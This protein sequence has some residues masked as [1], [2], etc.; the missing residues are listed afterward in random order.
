ML[1]ISSYVFL[2]RRILVGYYMSAPVRSS[3]DAWYREWLS[4]VEVITVVIKFPGFYCYLPYLTYSN[5]KSTPQS[6]KPTSPF[7]LLEFS[8]ICIPW[9]YS[10]ISVKM[11]QHK[12]WGTLNTVSPQD[13]P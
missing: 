8:I 13:W 12:E 10:N 11:S 4:N 3:L 2:P 9:K 1:G 5:P 6:P 7:V